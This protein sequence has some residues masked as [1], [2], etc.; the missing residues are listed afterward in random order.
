M[1]NRQRILIV[2]DKPENLFSLERV[3]KPLESVDIVKAE[4]GN[5]AL[6]R[7]LDHDFAVIIL[8]VQMP[9]MDGYEVAELLR[10]DQKTRNIPIIFL[11]AV[12]TDTIH[13]HKG[14]ESGAVDF[15]TKPYDSKLLLSKVKIFLELDGYREN[16]EAIIEENTQAV[17]ERHKWWQKTFDSVSDLICILDDKFKIL[18]ANQAMVDFFGGAVTGKHCYELFHQ[19]SC[20]V[21]QCLQRALQKGDYGKKLVVNFPDSGKTLEVSLSAVFDDK[22]RI[23]NYVHIASDITERLLVDEKL[24]QSEKMQAVGQL[25]GGVAHDFNNQLSGILGYGD[26]LVQRLD[27]PVLHRFAE[28]ICAAANRSAD[29]TKKLLA[30]S[31]KGQ[32]EY[33]SVDMHDVIQETVDMLTH[34][35]DKRID[36]P[37][38][39]NASEATVSGDISQLQN[40]L[41]NIAVNARDAMPDGGALSFSTAVVDPE[42]SL[43]FTD[44]VTG[45][46]HAFDLSQGADSLAEKYLV[47]TIKDTGSG[48]SEDVR[49]HIFEPFFTTKESG[50][51]TGM[52][53]ASVYGTIKQH[54]GYVTV[55]ST[56]GKGTVF[57]IYLPMGPRKKAAVEA[58]PSISADRPEK[59]TILIVDDEEDIR[60]LTR[61]MLEEIGHAVLVADDGREA[62]SLYRRRWRE[63]DVVILDMIMPRIG[64][65]N[66]FQMI[67]KI[68]PDVKVILAS[69]YSLNDDAQSLLNEGVL[70]FI[71]KPFNQS[72]LV[73]TVQRVFAEK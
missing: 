16:L 45:F 23:V 55:D 51:G 17:I 70:E 64:G 21:E 56:M 19:S 10:S 43:V 53:L 4:S 72:Q 13:V 3:L 58:M 65:R 7:T 73:D 31:R 67:K 29:L 28:N 32:V 41:L 18:I 5:Q 34:S 8:D 66:T 6:A 24:R 36:L 37:V 48:M 69:G 47:I 1:K 39:L 71:Q 12:M 59:L 50:K 40:A 49:K 22:G 14:Y 26:M 33:V 61:D 52:G 25:A 35:I 11:S 15:L 44:E 38:E 62:I 27:D 2:D 57:N 30:F 60:N 63:I 54:E 9:E 20:P 68:N 46:N 42:T